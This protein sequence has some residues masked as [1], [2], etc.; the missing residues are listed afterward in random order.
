[1]KKST[2]FAAICCL[3]IYSLTACGGSGTAPTAGSASADDMLKLLPVESTGV[4]FVDFHKAMS[5]EAI[6]NAIQE[7]ENYEKY[8]EFVEKTGIDPKEDVY[9]IAAS[10]SQAETKGEEIGAGIVNLKYDPDA[11]LNMIKEKAAEE[12]K[13]YITE[14]YN[15]TQMYFWEEK[16]EEGGFAF[17][18]ASNAIVGNKAGVK[19]II[20]VVK[21]TKE[22]V[23]KNEA[24]SSLLGKTNKKA[25]LWGAIVIPQEAAEKAAEN[26]MMS[27]LELLRL[28]S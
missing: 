12:G 16:D 28:L 20:D 18:D 8:M 7:D 22:N 25:M 2:V 9:Y 3:I 13:N 4:F 23:Y 27:E 19:S 15:G 6:G 26:P 14:E 1:M 5:I 24:L 10:F 21:G 11:L 17:L